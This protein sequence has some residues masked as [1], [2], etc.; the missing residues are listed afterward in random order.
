MPKQRDEKGRYT[1]QDPPTT[2]P[3]VGAKLPTFKLTTPIVGK[4]TLE[5]LEEKQRSGQRLTLVG[6]QTLLA[7]EMKRKQKQIGHLP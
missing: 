6:R 2:K 7:Y 5:E 3:L 4:P 1:K